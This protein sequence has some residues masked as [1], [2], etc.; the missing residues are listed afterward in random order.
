MRPP[1]PSKFPMTSHGVG[2]DI[3]W[4]YTLYKLFWF[5]KHVFFIST[6][7]CVCEPIRPS[8]LMGEQLHWQEKLQVLLVLHYKF[9]GAVCVCNICG[10]CCIC[11]YCDVRRLNQHAVCGW[12][13]E[14]LSSWNQVPL[15]G[16][17]DKPSHLQEYHLKLKSLGTISW[18]VL[19]PGG[20]Y[21][22]DWM[23]M[24]CTFLMT[25]ITKCPY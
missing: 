13:G 14:A 7:W 23:L 8:L 17:F 4:N 25:G 24:R 16:N 6:L 3:F 12:W 2:M 19:L 18:L 22:Q 20:R 1:T 5:V 15:S 11:V 9:S 21:V 10:G